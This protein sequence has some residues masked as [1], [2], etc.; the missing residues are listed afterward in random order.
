MI[1]RSQMEM[2]IRLD[3]I[4]R[5]VANFFETDLSSSLLGLPQAAREHFDR[6]R[7]FIHSFYIEQHGFWPPRDFEKGTVRQQ[8]YASM[9]FDFRS[10]Y[11]HLVDMQS[12]IEMESNH[13]AT[14][15]ICTLQN[16]QAFDRKHNYEGLPHPLPLCPRVADPENWSATNGRPNSSLSR[17]SSLNPLRKR[18][19]NRELR[20]ELEAKALIDAS[21]RD[22]GIME[23]LLVRRY[24]DFEQHSILDESDR[25]SVI[26]GR[27]VRWLLIYAVL[28]T[29]ISAMQAPTEVRNTEGLSYSLCCHI[30]QELPWELGTKVSLSN[31]TSVSSQ[32]PVEP[33]TNPL[34][35]SW[36][37][38]SLK[39]MNDKQN[40]LSPR[41]STSRAKKE[42]LSRSIS[43]A[44]SLRRLLSKRSKITAEQTSTNKKKPAF[45]E[46]FVQGYGNGLNQ[47]KLDNSSGAE[48]ARTNLE[49][50]TVRQ[51]ER[52]A[53][54]TSPSS[55]SSTGVSRE[56][57]N[58]SDH[59]NCS[60]D[61]AGAVSNDSGI[62]MSGMNRLAIADS[63]ARATKGKTQTVKA[64]DDMGTVHFNP[65]TWDRV[66]CA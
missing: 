17:R 18:Q 5:C 20:M 63:N 6:F 60:C 35:L 36:S 29:L 19:A 15:G 38:T 9:Y 31:A 47:V 28:Q 27:K 8:L 52:D 2:D 54:D 16:L 51:A 49:D 42:P 41:Q 40:N 33:D 56:P 62:E 10:L 46:I 43:K 53:D 24:S 30:P 1:T 3:R 14:G 26:D 12:S 21:N 61:S 45:C 13:T 55:P 22:W 34:M 25:V 65:S 50:G 39:S 64:L 32:S 57:S 44:P 37:S 48:D 58:A 7:S 11:H 23:C 4:S 59:S 66:L